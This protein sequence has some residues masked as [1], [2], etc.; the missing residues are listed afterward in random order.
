M[1]SHVVALFITALLAATRPEAAQAK[2]LTAERLVTMDRLGDASVSSD[3]RQI[4][5]VVR[6]TSPDLANTSRRILL[7][8]ADRPDAPHQ[9]I[10]AAPA[11]QD[12]PSWA[13]DDRALYFRGPD[14]KGVAQLWRVALDGSAPAQLTRGPLDVGSYRVA[15]DNRFVV[16]SYRVY[17]DCPTFECTVTRAATSSKAGTLYTKLNVRF[18][19]SYGD[20]RYNALF[21]IDFGGAAPVPLMA[22]ME[23]DVPTRPLGT[24]RAYTISPD[25]K[26]LVFAARPS[27]VSPNQSTM[28]RLYEVSLT[29]PAA[30]REIDGNAEVSFLNPAFSPEGRWLAYTNAAPP[31]SDGDRKDLVVRNLASGEVRQ[32]GAALD[33]WPEAITWSADGKTIFGTGDDEGQNSLFAYHLSGKVERLPVQGVAGVDVSARGLLLTMG[34][35]DQPGQLFVTDMAGRLQRQITSVA[36]AQL[37]DVTMAPTHSIVFEGWNGEPVQ[38]FVTEPVGRV[39]GQRYPVIFLIHGGP[40]G[41]YQDEWSF[42][43]NPQVWAARGYATVMVNFHGS[44]GRGQAFAHAVLRHRG[45]RVLE[46]LQRGWDAALR[47]Y[48]FLDGNRGCAMGS[49]FG[50]YM[51]FWLAGVWNEP[52][53]CFIAHAGT[54]D[55][56]A[57]SSDLLW[58]SDRQIGG[59]PWESTEE[60]EK[61]NA[62]NHV[63]KW[64][65]PLL[66][67]HGGRDF[68]VP[69]DQGLSAFAIAQQRGVSSELFFMPNENHIISG[70]PALLQ[71]YDVVGNWLDRWTTR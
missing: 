25:S 10:V 57:Y 66:I 60:V 13:A 26:S 12:M 14:D 69:F 49:S 31:G 39:P 41:T 20:G 48:P 8:D 55:S 18:Y 67:T 51:V 17:P 47:S 37:A 43:R 65:K 56:R 4:A 63:A 58:H 44:T 38:A 5:Y 28:H 3:G 33:R 23:T 61:F 21:K 46:D 45:D 9:P 29:A 30:P 16:A 15:P 70:A 19:D 53:R 71:W 59:K 36:A 42:G 35:F 32:I 50:G 40:H 34:R 11:W 68:R 27:G 24:E 2:G 62:I 7:I 64:K 54:L 22:G 1:K 6:T 52:W